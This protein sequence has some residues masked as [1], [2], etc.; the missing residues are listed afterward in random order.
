MKR[1]YWLILFWFLVL[2]VAAMIFIFSA[3][4]GATSSQTSSGIIQWLMRT[5]YP[6][7]DQLSIAD[8][9]ALIAS[10]QFA[11]RKAAHF[12]EFALLGFS[13]RLLFHLLI[14]RK[15]SLL[16]WIVGTLY[17]CTDELH[18]TLVSNRAGMWQD[19]CIDSAGVLFG[20]LAAL[21]ILYLRKLRQKAKKQA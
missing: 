2:S 6:H 5:L 12:S 3:Q 1:T 16:A 11:V 17:A 18:Q 10:W 21:L 20:V 13:L 7:Y 15:P 4:D 9:N 19:V 8:K 14:R